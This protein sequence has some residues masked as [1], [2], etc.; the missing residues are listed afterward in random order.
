MVLINISSGQLSGG[1]KVKVASG[2]AMRHHPHIVILDDPTNYLDSEAFCVLVDAIKGFKGGIVLISHNAWFTVNMFP[3]TKVMTPAT[4]IKPRRL[5]VKK[6]SEWMK[7][8]MK[9]KIEFKQIEELVD[10]FGN[11]VKLAQQKKKELSRADT[12]KL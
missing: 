10:D 5:E 3:D 4:D 2:A 7:K 6:D 1:Q 8:A 9:R 11:T 12:K